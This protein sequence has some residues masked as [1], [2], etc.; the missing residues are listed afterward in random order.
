[1]SASPSPKTLLIAGT[2]LLVVSTVVFGGLIWRAQSSVILS[3]P[4]LTAAAYVPVGVDSPVVKNTVW[5]APSALARGR[6]WLYDLFTPPEIF[7]NTRSRQ[8][9]VSAQLTGD[10][11]AEVPFGLELV[12]V[13]PEP[14]RL[15]LIGYVGGAGEARGIFE[16]RRT[17]EVFLASAGHRV[18]D[19][20]I[21]IKAFNVRAEAVVIPESTS[22][23]QR[24]ATA[25]IQDLRAK[26][27]LTLT[28]RER[29]FT[30]NVFGIVALE[31]E[32]TPR[33]VLAGDTLKL[34]TTSYRIERIAT[35][36]ATIEV[37]KTAPDLAA[38]V[39]RTIPLRFD[40]TE[41][42]PLSP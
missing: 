32:S 41:T 31:G 40:L 8:F 15:Q 16:N 33:E 9:A 1:M 39:R 14:F 7:Y 4:T 38:P 18:A 29:H 34:G 3:Q 12:S 28:Q 35:E 6:D 21:E 17:G 5:E 10:E 22:F 24:V 19:L 37:T 42:A 23:S 25:T 13:R 2:S 30:G 36:P 11:A 20:A 26:R 27:D